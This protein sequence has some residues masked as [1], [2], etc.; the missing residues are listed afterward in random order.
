VSVTGSS[1]AIAFP[2]DGS[3]DGSCAKPSCEN[4]GE[5]EGRLCCPSVSRVEEFMTP[6]EV[7]FSGPLVVSPVRESGIKRMELR[8]GDTALRGT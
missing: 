8:E 1:S 5:L 3:G 2:V 6:N 4:T 7:A